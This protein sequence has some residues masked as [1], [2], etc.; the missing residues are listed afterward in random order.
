[1]IGVD[2]GLNVASICVVRKGKV[3]FSLVFKFSKEKEL[4]QAQRAIKC[5]S[6]IVHQ[7]LSYTNG[8]PCTVAVEEPIYSWG[9]RNPKAFA[10]SVELFTLINRGLL[11]K[12]YKV[13]TVNNKTAKLM[14]GSGSKDKDEMIQAYKRATGLYPGHSTQYGKETIADSYFIALAGLQKLRERGNK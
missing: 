7:I 5:A 3:E 14:A 13:I 8:D 10:K 12:G 1:M 6:R 11:V 9:R 2:I 4:P